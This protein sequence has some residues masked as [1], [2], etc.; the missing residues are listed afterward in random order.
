MKK[1]WPRI[2]LL[3]LL[4]L[5]LAL[6][7]SYRWEVSSWYLVIPVVVLYLF[8]RLYIV[9]VREEGRIQAAQDLLTIILLLLISWELAT[10][11]LDLLERLLFPTPGQVFALLF[12][13]I[14]ELSKG[15]FS[16]LQ[17]L[18]LGYALA[19]ITAVPLALIVGWYR[20][21]Y[22]VVNPLTK[23]LGSIPPIVYIPYAIALLPS[24][25]TASVFIIFVAAFWPIFINTLNGVL[26]IDKRFLDTART[27]N[28]DEGSLFLGVILPGTLPALFSGATLGLVLAFILL[29]SAEMI[30]ATSGLGWYIKYYADFADYPR[31]V[32]GI[33]FVGLVVTGL[34]FLLNLL[35]KYLLRWRV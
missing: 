9:L 10:S 32:V 29:T 16:S 18:V 7:P 17:L 26:N 15:L 13:E 22:R 5:L 28:V 34:T 25:K 21:L 31:V 11:K 30:G 6:W 3:F 23:V 1:I 2:H 12:T 19:L 33:I 20:R 14:P 8:F 24:F 27:L 35:E 4:L